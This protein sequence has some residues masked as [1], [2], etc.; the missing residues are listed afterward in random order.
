MQQVEYQVVE[1]IPTVEEYLAL[2]EA[3]GWGW[4][5]E[6]QTSNG[7]IHSSGSPFARASDGSARSSS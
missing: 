1:R 7:C 6:H 4:L 5:D 2:R 3:V